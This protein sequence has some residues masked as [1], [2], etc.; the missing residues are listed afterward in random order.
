MTGLTALAVGCDEDEEDVDDEVEENLLGGK[1]TI[2]GSAL[3]WI[4][5]R[6]GT[7]EL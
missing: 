3:T 1:G 2:V 7:G 5:G 4:F 6:S